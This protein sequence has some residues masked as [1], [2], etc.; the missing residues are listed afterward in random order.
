MQEMK[1]CAAASNMMTMMKAKKTRMT[2]MIR[3][4]SVAV[5]FA[6]SRPFVLREQSVGRIIWSSASRTGK[7][8]ATPAMCCR[9]LP[10]ALDDYVEALQRQC[11][12]EHDAWQSL[13][14]RGLAV[15]ITASGD[16]TSG[17]P[18]I[19]EMGFGPMGT[20][21]RAFHHGQPTPA[22]VP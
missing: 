10:A 19:C 20:Q 2:T 6:S 1:T 3:E 9:K 21:D 4:R 15:V 7:K 16:K 22:G 14:R 8:I 11:Q 18:R 12:Q 13:R 5:P 17:R